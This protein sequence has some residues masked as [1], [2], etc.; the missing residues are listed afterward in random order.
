MPEA[1]F[2]AAAN[3]NADDVISSAGGVSLSIILAEPFLYLQGFNSAEQGERPPTILRGSLVVAVSK[4]TKIKTITLTF[5]GISRTEWPEGIP[6]KKAELFEANDIHSHIWPFFNASFPMAE[7]SSGAHLVKLAGSSRMISE[8]DE[9]Q[10]TSS[11]STEIDPTSDER[12][13]H[14]RKLSSVNSSSYRSSSSSALT[15]FSSAS[16]RNRSPSLEST[17]AIKGFA[18]KIKRAASPQPSSNSLNMTSSLSGLSLGPHRSFSKKEPHDQETLSKGYRVFEPGLYIYNFELPLPQSL[19]ESI[20]CNFGSVKYFLEAVITR[21]GTFRPKISGSKAVKIVRASSDN[22]L[23]AS[24]PIAI[25]RDWENQLHYDI[26]IGGKA[27][28]IGSQIPIA[29][30]LTP[31]SKVRCHRIRIYIT[32]NSEY[33]CKNKKVHRIEPTK[34][35]LLKEEIPEDGLQGSLLGEYLG[36]E[37]SSCTEME[38]MIDIPDSF[39]DRRDHLHPNTGYENI[40]VHHWI[41]LVLRLSKA[42]P[43]FETGKRKF[44][45]VSID[46]PIS[47]LDNH[48]TNANLF[49]PEYRGPSSR[50][51][52]LVSSRSSSMVPIRVRDDPSSPNTEM[53]PIH[54]LRKPSIAPPPFEADRAP[55]DANI[56]LIVPP[57]NYEAAV[58]AGP[59][60]PI[61]VPITAADNASIISESSSSRDSETRRA[62][63]SST[64]I[65]TTET[66]GSGSSSGASTVGA[67]S[68]AS[69]RTT[70]MHVS[71]ASV[72]STMSN[73]DPLSTAGQSS[74]STSTPAAAEDVDENDPLSSVPVPISETGSGSIGEN[75]SATSSMSDVSSMD[76]RPY[77]GRPSTVNSVDLVDQRSIYSRADARRRSSTSFADMTPMVSRDSFARLPLLKDVSDSA[78]AEE[79]GDLGLATAGDFDDAMSLQSTPSLWIT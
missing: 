71:H 23:E 45:E 75:S 76:P 27:F 3:L 7:Y 41:K 64:S 67:A 13:N 37:I 60:D 32:E 44:Y 69:S 55:P 34:K 50:R 2:E 79:D 46:S 62:A 8:I 6:P 16:G 22:N 9:L 5:K 30:K 66:F 15:S 24:E 51:P 14:R 21:P 4:P 68:Q 20:D 43:E 74:A 73:D 42:N 28:P 53:R 31:L 33:Y 35:F 58:A 52:S 36:T 56:T 18:S 38:Y 47:L 26:I 65:S 29:F 39:H 70:P 78:S 77:L 61:R 10:P 49:L 12:V 40:K 19:P 57:P 17:R 48:C 63:L 72:S 1:A 54:L 59:P 25:S 11:Q